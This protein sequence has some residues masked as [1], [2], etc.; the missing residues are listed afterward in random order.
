MIELTT[1]VELLDRA[2]AA[3]VSDL[4]LHESRVAYWRDN[5][6]LVQANPP[7]ESLSCL[8]PISELLTATGRGVPSI[9]HLDFGFNYR[10]RRFRAS[11]YRAL[12]KLAAVLRVV[13]ENHLTLEQI[14]VPAAFTK[15]LDQMEGL[16]LVSG[17]TGDGK[18]TT[19]AAALSYLINQAEVKASTLEDPVEYLF[20]SSKSIVDQQELGSDFVDFRSALEGVLRQDPDVIL[21]GE[22]RDF[23]TFE[24]A[25]HAATTGHLVLASVHGA[26]A[27][28]TIARIVDTFPEKVR[29][30]QRARFAQVL[31]AIFTQQLA[32]TRTG[33]RAIGEFMVTTEAIR[34]LIRDNRLDS[35]PGEIRTGTKHGMRSMDMHLAQLVRSKVLDETAAIGRA[36]FPDSFKDLLAHTTQ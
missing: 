21:I 16:F 25:C 7:G 10:G 24:I 17:A 12:G 35:I 26:S 23:Q 3:G 34:N 11:I 31:T 4:H 1:S 28:K 19:L 20:A 32:P 33:R 8:T 6:K 5:G 18:S 13:P 14:G 15:V 2:L 29:A 9:G 36:H 30:E 27:Q 22:L